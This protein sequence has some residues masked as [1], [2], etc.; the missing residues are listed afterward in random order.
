MILQLNPPIPVQT[1]KGPGLAQA[2]IDYGPE[3]HLL[4][5]VFLDCNGQCWTYPNPD[6]RGK[7]NLTMGRDIKG[8]ESCCF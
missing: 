5:V 4:W 8:E 6:I 2:L 7:L 3:H 1:P